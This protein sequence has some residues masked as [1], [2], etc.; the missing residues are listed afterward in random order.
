MAVRNRLTLNL[1]RFL[2]GSHRGLLRLWIA[3]DAYHIDQGEAMH[4][5]VLTVINID[6]A[7]VKNL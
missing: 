6:E 7:M 3:F 4:Y 5:N 2:I 1:K